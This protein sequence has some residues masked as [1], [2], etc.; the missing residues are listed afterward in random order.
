MT[1]KSH[2]NKSRDK[3]F[4]VKGC[5]SKTLAEIKKEQG[6]SRDHNCDYRSKVD[7]KMVIKKV[8]FTVR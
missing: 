8:V 4:L 5:L 6:Y 3:A 2:L 7:V 1:L